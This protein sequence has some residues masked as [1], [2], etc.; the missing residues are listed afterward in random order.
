MALRASSRNLITDAKQWRQ[1]Q[2][3]IDQRFI[4]LPNLRIILQKHRGNRSVDYSRRSPPQHVAQV[5]FQKPI[6]LTSFS[7]IL[8]YP[9]KWEDN[10]R[11][12][13]FSPV[14]ALDSAVVG[15]H[16]YLAKG[17][18]DDDRLFRGL[19]SGVEAVL[20]SPRDVDDLDFKRDV[21]VRELARLVIPAVSCSVTPQPHQLDV[22]VD[23]A[24]DMDAWMNEVC[25]LPLTGT[26]S[27]LT[28]SPQ[29]S[30]L[31]RE[32]SEYIA[33]FYDI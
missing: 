33:N 22:Q 7:S 12:L 26:R 29:V 19:S 10:R 13:S 17:D 9:V 28:T 2:S 23:G 24:Y 15:V 16:A 3:D 14:R 11:G 32:G 6:T 8:D 4:A 27:S 30:P 1:L 21:S 25:T 5:F 31:A 20:V 18:Y